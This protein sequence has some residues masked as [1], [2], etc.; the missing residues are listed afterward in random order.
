MTALPVESRG[1][2]PW[3]PSGRLWSLWDIIMRKLPIHLV[4]EAGQKVE[5]ARV[6][7]NF[8]EHDDGRS[9][10]T[11]EEREDRVKVLTRLQSFAMVLQMDAAFPVLERAIKD[12]P[13]TLREFDITIGVVED[14]LRKRQAFF[15]APDKAAFFEQDDLLKEDTR[16]KFPSA[17]SE[18]REAANAYACGLNTACVFHCARAA[19]IGTRALA[20]RL[21]CKFN[22]PLDEVELAP[23]LD[24]CEKVIGDMKN[25]K[26]SSKKKAD[27]TFYSQAAFD[28]RLFKDAYRVHVAHARVSYTEPQAL[29]ILERS[30][31]FFDALAL[32]LKEPKPKKAAS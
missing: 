16:S 30:I 32:R 8:L 18:L 5:E 6:V 24:Q 13:N 28:F 10:L 26:R 23:M 29:S 15:I 21:G 14:E 12:L 3:P 11:R 4:L 19:E 1:A 9:P 2:S 27:L 25:Q 31:E 7:F 17:A 22:Q 20:K